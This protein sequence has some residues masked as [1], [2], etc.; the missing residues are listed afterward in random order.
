MRESPEDIA[1]LQS[2]IDE[3][4]AAAGRHHRDIHSDRARL[5]AQQVV[6]RLQGMRV[7]VVATV[8]SDGRPLTGPVDSFLYKGEVRFGTAPY[9]VRARHL[10]RSPA[11]SA[12]Y[13]EGEGLVVTVHGTAE[14]L[15]LEGADRDFVDFLRDHYGAETFEGDL[16]GAPYYRIL[17]QRFFAADMSVYAT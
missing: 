9:A 15:D 8:T 16:S 17:P 11:I 10:A 14:Q 1:R 12:T 6:D 13:V 2:I 3:S 4:Y 5:T 7:F